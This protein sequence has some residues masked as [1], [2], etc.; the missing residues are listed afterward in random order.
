[1]GRKVCAALA[2]AWML[3][4]LQC[5]F[6]SE[7]VPLR[8]QLY[9]RTCPQYVCLLAHAS[10]LH[11]LPAALSPRD[12]QSAFASSNS[13]TIHGFPSPAL[14]VDAAPDWRTSAPGELRFATQLPSI[15]TVGNKKQEAIQTPPNSPRKSSAVLAQRGEDE[16]AL[17][18]RSILRKTFALAKLAWSV[19][20]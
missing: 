2:A 18:Q 19:F 8:K 20:S 3:A 5:F 17:T 10:R 15:H 12:R 7:R 9:A 11:R 13:D 16:S 6:P 14:A 4:S 1:M